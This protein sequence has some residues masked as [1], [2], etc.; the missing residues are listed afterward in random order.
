MSWSVP[1][2]AGRPGADLSKVM[3]GDTVDFPVAADA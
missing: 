1:G 3:I 2:M